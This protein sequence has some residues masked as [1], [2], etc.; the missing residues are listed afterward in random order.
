MLPGDPVDAIARFASPEQKEALRED[1]GLDDP[2]WVQ[3]GRWLSD[4]VTGDLG[5]YYSVTG[6]RPVMDR[7]SDSL[8]VSLQ[9]M[10]YAQ[11][12]ALVIAIPAGVSPPTGPAPAPTRRPTRRRSG[13]WPSPTSPSPWCWRT[14]SG[15]SSG[16]C[17]SAAT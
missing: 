14:T 2:V 15:S 5:N 9:L 4:F 3:Y 17:R 1:L 11:V 16:G 7:V 10:I 8:P 6:E 13:R 12:L